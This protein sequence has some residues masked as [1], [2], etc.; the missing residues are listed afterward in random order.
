MPGVPKMG[1]AGSAFT[2]EEVEIYEACTCLDGA[3]LCSIHDKFIIMGG[4]RASKGAEEEKFH[5]RIGHKT[6][7][8]LHA[9]TNR[10]SVEEVSA[11]IRL[12]FWQLNR[13]FLPHRRFALLRLG[14]TRE[15]GR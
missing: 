12:P 5:K 7:K 15:K 13:C 3:E 6:A 1:S 8:N 11:G 10:G 2:Q 4:K 14:A 9:P